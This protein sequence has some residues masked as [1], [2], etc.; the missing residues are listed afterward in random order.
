MRAMFLLSCVALLAGCATATP[1]GPRFDDT[2]HQAVGQNQV[3][4][5]IYREKVFYLAQ[6][7]YI[8]STEI[9]IDGRLV[10]HVQNGG[11]LELEVAPG[12]H[13]ITAKAG[14]DRTTKPFGAVPQNAVYIEL[15]DKTRINKNAFVGGAIGATFD[16]VAG[17][18]SPV[19]GR[20][21]G[22]DFVTE[23]IALGQ[24][25]SLMRSN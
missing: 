17:A 6:A 23:P 1:T 22:V 16:A 13:T 5:Y 4:V 18:E 25:Q 12:Q 14:D 21:W 11:Y 2:Q 15:W 10:G 9:A 19:E 3:R 7:P 8:A 24:L 20:V